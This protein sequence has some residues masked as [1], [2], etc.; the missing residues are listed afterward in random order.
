MAEFFR[1]DLPEP[2]FDTTDFS[3]IQGLRG[4]VLNPDAL[5]GGA[6][7]LDARGVQ[8][9]GDGAA[10]FGQGVASV[11]SDMM[12]VANEQMRAIEIRQETDAENRMAD[13]EAKL[14]IAI[15][16]Q[17]DETKWPGIAQE[18]IAR[19][20]EEMGK[21]EM[22][23]AARDAIR[24]KA[25]GWK[26]QLGHFVGMASAK[27]S[28]QRAQEGI[29]GKYT[30]ALANE[31]Y[32]GAAVLLKQ[33][34]TAHFMGEAW[35]ADREVEAV[36]MAKAKAKEAEAE[37]YKAHEGNIIEMA[38]AGHLDLALKQIEAPGFM[39]GKADPADLESLRNKAQA[40]WKDRAAATS[41]DIANRIYDPKNPLTVAELNALDSPFLTPAI[42]QAMKGRIGAFR[43]NQVAAFK[44]EHGTENFVRMMRAAREVDFSKMA[45][46]AAALKFDSM[47]A[48]VRATVDDDRAGEVTQL[49]HQKFG[50]KPDNLTAPPEVRSLVTKNMAL[51][52][53]IMAEKTKR[54]L[55]EAEAALKADGGDTPANRAA[56]DAAKKADIANQQAINKQLAA[57]ERRMKPWYDNPANAG[58]DETK[59]LE[60]AAKLMLPEMRKSVL[61]A[62]DAADKAQGAPADRPPI[63]GPVRMDNVDRTTA[64]AGD[65]I[66]LPAGSDTGPSTLLI[67]DGPP[68]REGAKWVADKNGQTEVV[69]MTEEDIARWRE[70][71][72]DTAA[73]VWDREANGFRM[74]KPSQLKLDRHS[75]PITILP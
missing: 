49:L 36:K 26:N 42:R 5:S 72:S 41:E 43:A 57:I 9:M 44:A 10:R 71:K 33:P 45:P 38:K 55:A 32:A 69:P 47:I 64:G 35:I 29:A 52:Y 24:M 74:V 51:S 22:T 2:G 67:P 16:E 19:F 13:T 15:T 17:Q 23:A 14:Q 8:A 54:P 21:L 65:V 48:D 63:L 58:A 12:A 6:V 61:D 59:A 56:R 53:E 66:D 25:A 75:M 37:T 70:D 34:G 39:N 4:I 31:D 1:R 73:K 50:S 11:G 68:P 18:H 28:V 46:D 62:R 60:E 20:D 40:A 3:R 30:R 7:Q 27:R